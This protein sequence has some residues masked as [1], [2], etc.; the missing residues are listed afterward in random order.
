[1]ATIKPFLGVR[2]TEAF[3]SSIAALPYDV[4]DRKK[5]KE[6]A[7]AHPLSFLNIDRPETQ[8][9]D[10][11]D[12]YSQKVYEKARE[13]FESMFSEGA[14]IQD[15][16]ACYYLYSLTMNGRT[17]TGIVG[18][19][20]I[21]DYLN[22]TI[23]KHENTREEKE[24]DRINHV[25]TMSAQTGPI[26]L[27]YRSVRRLKDVILSVKQTACIYDFVSEDG[28]RHQVWKVDDPNTLTTISKSFAEIDHIYIADGHH[29]AA[30]AVKVGLK[31]RNNH[32]SYTGTEEFNYF[33]SVLF[34]EDE[35]MIYDYNRVLKDLNGFSWSEVMDA[36][37]EYFIISKVPE[38]YIG[39]DG[40]PHPQKRGEIILYGNNTWSL[41]TIKPECYSGN[42]VKDLDVSLLQELVLTPIFNIQD[43]RTDSRI[44]FI[45][46]IFGIGRLKEL[47]DSK[48][49]AAA[50]AMYPTSMQ[51]LLHVADEGLLM[52]P[53]S[54]WFEPKLRSGL[55]IHKI[56]R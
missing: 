41:L 49:G 26:F 24:I 39:C 31:R 3:A 55:F 33:L 51:E 7:L 35:L 16:S 25:D 14:F 37:S 42:P 11:T 46:G 5:A 9:S 10:D 45:G 53:K 52:P 47:V 54:T 30:S 20:S 27:T 22:G 17:Q 15:S 38:Q 43:P 32:T 56:E 44:D 18:C 6:Y 50:F 19:A 28:I 8:F 2:P 36:I 1:M 48:Q 21:D 12:M 4:Y 23:K 13:I 40:Y 29:R 34:P